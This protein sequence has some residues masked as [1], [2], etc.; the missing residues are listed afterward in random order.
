MVKKEKKKAKGKCIFPLLHFRPHYSILLVLVY[1]VGKTL[2][3]F[4]DSRRST[5][6]CVIGYAHKCTNFNCL[7][8]YYHT[9]RATRSEKGW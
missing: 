5:G 1:S 2:G 8:V 3:R 7:H 4:E 6:V 9:G